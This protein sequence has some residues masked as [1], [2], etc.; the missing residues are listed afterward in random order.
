M[1]ET[2]IKYAQA[3]S[4]LRDFKKAITQFIDELIKQFPTESDL[5]IMRI[6]IHDQIET[7]FL[8]NQ[9]IKFV[10]PH[11]KLIQERDDRFFLEKEDIFGNIDSSK[12]V[13]FKKLWKSSNLDK[14]DKEVIWNWFEHFIKFCENYINIFDPSKAN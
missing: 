6:F 8:M 13:H 3:I 1:D 12:I 14:D 2:D 4:L 11:K 5:V 9:F 7:I 10:Y